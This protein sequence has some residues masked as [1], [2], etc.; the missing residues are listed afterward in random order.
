LSTSVA[1]IALNAEV[2]VR[3]ISSLRGQAGV[4]SSMVI[5]DLTALM[6]ERLGR[7][8]RRLA[9]ALARTT[10]LRRGRAASDGDHES[11]RA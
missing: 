4:V 8:P 1:P 10:R 2:V 3:S 5:D 7:R 6:V 9:T 11:A